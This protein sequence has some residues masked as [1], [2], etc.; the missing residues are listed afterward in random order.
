[1]GRYFRV[2][3]L[4]QIGPGLEIGLASIRPPEAAMIADFKGTEPFIAARGVGGFD[5]WPGAG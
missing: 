2:S 3:G 4:G 5:F 1:M